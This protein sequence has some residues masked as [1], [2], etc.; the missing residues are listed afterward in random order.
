[1]KFSFIMHNAPIATVGRIIFSITH[2]KHKIQNYSHEVTNITPGVA[3]MSN[4]HVSTSNIPMQRDDTMVRQLS[5]EPH[6]HSGEI[7]SRRGVQIEESFVNIEEKNYVQFPDQIL[8]AV[9]N[10]AGEEVVKSVTE[11]QSARECSH[12]TS[13][14]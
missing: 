5:R 9:S 2:R 6:T 14:S 7:T 11:V 8:G 13:C 1:M 10:V 3:E 12:G 4:Q